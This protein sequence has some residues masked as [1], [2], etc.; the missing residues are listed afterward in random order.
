MR[1]KWLT[2]AGI[3]AAGMLVLVA[4]FMLGAEWGKRMPETVVIQGV[5]N[6]EGDAVSAA[7]FS[8]FWEVWKLIDENY[9]KSEEVRGQERI[10][11]AIKGLVG[12]LGDPYSEF[13]PP[14]E[15]KKFQ[16]DIRGNFGGI[17]AELGIRRNQLQI[18]AP[19]KDTPASR[20]G[21][22]PGDKILEVNASS[23]DGISIDEAVSWIRGPQ[24]TKVEL[25]IFREGWEKAREFEL[26][27]EN[28]VIPTLDFEMKDKLAYVQLYSFNAQAERLFAH[29]MRDALNQGAEGLV[30]DLRNN[31]GGYLEVAVDMAG[32]FLPRDTLVVTESGREMNEEFRAAG[33]EALTEFPMIILVNG[34]SASA[35][36]ILAG[37]LRDVRNIKLVGEETYGKGTV[38][39][40]LPLRDR[41][42]LKVTIAHWVLPS[43]A[44]L[45]EKG[46]APDVKVE[47]SD[48]DREADRDPQLEKALE[49]LRADIS[50]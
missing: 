48:E 16:D 23:T 31:P 13:F 19:L 29:A 17:G 42:A 39:Q 33:N 15:N 3:S 26:T 10:Y 46:L 14:E 11:G 47:V 22:Q 40:L 45:E 38:Q 12:S 43:G 28:I 27:R 7:D 1:K 20:A 25:L 30:L 6:M 35:S 44:V 41:S 49:V 50:K 2:I 37:A 5:S 8:R 34:G 4:V 18:I 9:L 36:E 24:G 32:W 21:I